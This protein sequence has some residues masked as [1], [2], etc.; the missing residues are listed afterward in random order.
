M[1]Q[2]EEVQFLVLHNYYTPLSEEFSM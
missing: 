2:L 1:Y